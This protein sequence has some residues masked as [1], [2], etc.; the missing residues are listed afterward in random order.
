MEPRKP[1]WP[2]GPPTGESPQDV[3][4]PPSLLSRERKRKPCGRETALRLRSQ[5]GTTDPPSPG[6]PPHPPVDHVRGFRFLSLL[7]HVGGIFFPIGIIRTEIIKL[8]SFFNEI[9]RRLETKRNPAK[10]NG[11]L[12]QVRRRGESRGGGRRS[13]SHKGGS[14]GPGT[15]TPPLHG[16]ALRPHVLDTLLPTRSNPTPRF[17]RKLFPESSQQHD[18][19]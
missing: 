17:P 15:Q 7:F 19:S 2:H 6:P 14:E 18:S 4:S 8:F 3:A 10:A 11:R 12:P 13:R 1:L 16:C 9:R 5:G